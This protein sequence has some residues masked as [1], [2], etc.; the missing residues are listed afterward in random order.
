M[1]PGPNLAKRI[2]SSEIVAVARTVSGTSF[3]LG[4]EISSDIVLRVERVLKGNLTPGIEIS[5]HLRVEAISWRLSRNNRPSP[6]GCTE[7]GS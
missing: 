4:S 7:S 5:A 2:E 6:S 1:I 3:A